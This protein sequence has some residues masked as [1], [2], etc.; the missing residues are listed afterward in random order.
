MEVGYRWAIGGLQAGYSLA[1]AGLECSTDFYCEGRAQLKCETVVTF[2][3]CVQPNSGTVGSFRERVQL[4]YETVVTFEGCV[5][6]NSG[7]VVSFEG[8]CN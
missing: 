1:L 4:K 8:V 5:R 6:P 7:T 3:G 2:E